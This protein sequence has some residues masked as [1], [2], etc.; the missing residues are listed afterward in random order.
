MPRGVGTVADPYCSPVSQL[1]V[2]RAQERL[3]WVPHAAC[4]GTRSATARIATTVSQA[5]VFSKVHPHLASP[6]ATNCHVDDFPSGV[7]GFIKRA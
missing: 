4:V 1:G 3:P 7:Y 6:A 5:V 2:P